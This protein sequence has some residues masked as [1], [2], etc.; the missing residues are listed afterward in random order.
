MALLRLI[1][2]ESFEIVSAIFSR[3]PWPSRQGQR[4]TAPNS[5][6]LSGGDFREYSRR[7][8]IVVGGPS[9]NRWRMV[10]INSQDFERT[11]QL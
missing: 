2:S 6:D 10:N 5:K 8:R 9:A 7:L 3:L 1:A 4:K 11:V